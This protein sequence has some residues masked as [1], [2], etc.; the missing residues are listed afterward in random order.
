MT[1]LKISIA[2]SI[3]S[4]VLLLVVFELIRSRRLRERYACLA[5]HGCRALALSRGEAA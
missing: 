2:A 5:A 4:I 3:A 1:P